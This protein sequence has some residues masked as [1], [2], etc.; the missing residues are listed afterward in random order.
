[1]REWIAV[2]GVVLGMTS[3]C[4]PK[5]CPTCEPCPKTEPTPKASSCEI[6]LDDGGKR[7]VAASFRLVEKDGKQV[8]TG[9][10]ADGSVIAIP[11][12]PRSAAY[13]D[14]KRLVI[15]DVMARRPGCPC[16]LPQCWPFCLPVQDVLD[17][18]AG[19]LFPGAGGPPGGGVTDP[20]PPAPPPP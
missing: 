6:E 18:P 3:S 19:D 1:M 12:D 16:Q 9:T 11:L 15:G 5:S 7:S 10:L 13:I 2:W 14:G 4:K 17:K 20:V 8:M